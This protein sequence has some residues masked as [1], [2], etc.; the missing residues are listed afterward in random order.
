LKTQSVGPFRV[1]GILPA[2][3]S[4]TEILARVKTEIP[5]LYNVLGTA[6]MHCARYVKIRR[7]DG[8]LQIGPSISNHSWG[9]AVD[10][11]LSGR[12]DRQGDGKTYRGLLVLS[13]YFNAAGWY[14]GAAFPT[15]DAMH[16]EVS[17]SL[18]ARWK[19]AGKI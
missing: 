12:L 16:F 17:K 6:G 15:E 3:E 1:T 19:R 10:I 7:N 2:L 9:T 5:A 14:W 18:L 8:S 4:L 13:S 11:K